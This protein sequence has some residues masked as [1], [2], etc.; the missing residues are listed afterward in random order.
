[1]GGTA[2]LRFAVDAAQ[3]VSVALREGALMVVG[4]IQRTTVQAEHRP[5]VIGGVRVRRLSPRVK[6][7]Q[8]GAGARPQQ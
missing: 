3:A 8:P 6:F 1:M 2:L 4:G 5:Y 7:A